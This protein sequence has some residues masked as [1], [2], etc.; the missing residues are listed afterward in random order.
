ME[1]IIEDDIIEAQRMPAAS[2][3][4]V[5]AVLCAERPILR[6]RRLSSLSPESEHNSCSRSRMANDCYICC[7]QGENNCSY[8]CCD[9]DGRNIIESS[10]PSPS[11][12]DNSRRRRRRHRYGSC[13]RV[14]MAAMMILLAVIFSS[15]PIISTRTPSTL[16]AVAFSP[17][18]NLS[19]AR[20]SSSCTTQLSA[21]RK[22][23]GSHHHQ[24]PP[25]ATIANNNN[26]NNNNN[27]NNGGGGGRRRKNNVF[28]Q[29]TPEYIGSP[30]DIDLSP[31]VDK[32]GHIDL[33]KG[34]NDDNTHTTTK[35]QVNRKR[36]GRGRG[37]TINST[38][39]TTT[40]KN[41][42]KVNLRLRTLLLNDE[43]E[44]NPSL[45]DD[46]P[47][48]AQQLAQFHT[49]SKVSEEARR[50]AKESV[51]SHTEDEDDDED[52]EEGNDNDG[53]EMVAT[54]MSI[55]NLAGVNNAR[56]KRTTTAA[57]KQQQ[58]QRRSSIR[59]TVKETGSDSISS[60]TKSLGQH[61]L[62]HKDDEVLLG[63]QVRML[64]VLEDKRME[65]EEEMLR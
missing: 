49:Y 38:K 34:N 60:Y 31:P 55:N 54:T 23:V 30:Y 24:P 32:N 5:E 2:S 56:R 18:L 11:S 19:P 7:Q 44:I 46:S 42:N 4:V 51:S 17:S 10:L 33:T 12:D 13:Q 63:R 48:A 53:G 15:I 64:M 14:I 62:L 28:E 6:R 9:D 52:Y 45:P 20:F 43:G 59:A 26:A 27:N 40:I 58:Q 21:V 16:F 57:M 47:E 35:K 8:N 25:R 41:A 39:S 50:K 61:E 3:V 37:Q 29:F 1:S 65:L 22:R 36:G